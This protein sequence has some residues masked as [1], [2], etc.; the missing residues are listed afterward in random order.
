MSLLRNIWKLYKGITLYLPIIIGVI[1]AYT[2]IVWPKA[3]EVIMVLVMIIAMVA[4]MGISVVIVQRLKP[5]GMP[6]GSAAF[7]GWRDLRRRGLLGRRGLIL[8]KAF[9]R[10]LRFDQDGHLLTF[11][12]T[13]TGKGVGCVI[14]NLLDHPGS[15][16]VTDIKGENFA[17]TG[18]RREALGPVFPLAPFS[19]DIET[20]RY[21]PLDFIRTGEPED[22]DDAALIANLLVPNNGN[23][24][25]WDSEAENLIAM[26]LLYVV[27]EFPV[28][29][30]NLHQVWML[31]MLS[32]A[33]FDAML[34]HMQGSQHPAIRKAATGFCQKE[35]RE[36]SAV[37]STAQTHMKIWRSP[38]LA[39]ATAWSDFQ[40]EGLKQRVMSLYIVIPPELLSVYQ[41][42]LRLMVGLSISAMTRVQAK[43]EN[44]VVFFLD[45]IAALGRMGPVETAIGYLA[46]YG[47]SLW[48]FFQDLDQLQKTYPKWRS[49]IAN[50]NVRQAFG[51]SDY[52]TAKE[53]SAML[54]QR[55]MKVSNKSRSGDWLM[56]LPEHVSRQSSQ[57]AR[58]LLTPDEIM[59]MPQDSQLIFVQACRPIPAKKLR[60]FVERVFRASQNSSVSSQERK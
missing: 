11:A 3:G 20:A 27:H 21:N 52:E 53:L 34:A 8:G 44:R 57:I 2:G 47:V 22:V 32:R 6:H 14:P 40:L 36:R 7:A 15:V 59:T 51:V 54:G 56:P 9:W 42:F 13:R 31:L 35:E 38:N 50:C 29:H 16:V 33:D 48:L 45:E 25:F 60:Y 10:Y 4:I 28:D 39:R 26:L 17:T 19:R 58:P 5:V 1:A 43:P 24:S 30:R 23:Q 37:I 49:M 12:P 41:P 18:R 55:T 46:G